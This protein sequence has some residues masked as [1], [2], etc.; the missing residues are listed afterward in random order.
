MVDME[1]PED[2]PYVRD[3]DTDFEDTGEL[4]RERARE[5]VELLREAI[6]YH[7]HRYYVENDPVISDRVYDKLFDRLEQ[8]EKEFDLASPNSPTRR[9]G[10]EPVEE[11]ETVEHV[12][13][14]LSL[15]SSEEEQDVRSF[16]E[17]VRKEVGEV[18]YHCEPKFDGISI[19]IVYENGEYQGAV[20]RGNGVEGE[21]VSEN[22]RTIRSVPLELTHAPDFLAVRGEVFMP[23]TGF[24]QLNEERIKA[25]KDPFANPRN[26]A[27][28]TVRQLDPSKVAARPLDIY[29]Y[30]ILQDSEEVEDHQRAMEILEKLGFQVNEHNTLVS[31]IDGFIDYRER[32]VEMRD[33]L[34]YE[35]DGV[36]VKVNDY[37]ARR[38]LGTTASHPRWAFAY[39]FPAKKEETTVRKIAVQVG[40]TGKLTPVALLEPVD[41]HGVTVSR[42]TL[43]NASQVEKMGVSEGA[44]VRIERAGD[45]IP[46]VVEVVEE[47]EGGFEMPPECP[48]CNSEVEVEG[49]YHFCT[50][51]ISCEAQLKRS[52][53]HFTSRGA[54][55]IEGVGERISSQLVES[56]LVEE[57]P[58]IYS[59]E[60]NDILELDKFAERSAEKLLSEIEESKQVELSRFIFALGIRHVGKETARV[61]SR[62][63]TLEQLMEADTEDLQE[64]EEIGPEVAESI[65]S[66]FS[67][68][69]GEVV[70]RF[71]KAG[72]EPGREE[73]GDELEGLKLVLTGSIED[74]NRDELV[75][76]LERNGADVTSS[77]SGETDYL[78]VGDNPGET[79]LDDAEEQDVE[80]IDKEEFRRRILRRIT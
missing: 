30:D 3:V 16:D 1:E 25:G 26:A 51:G 70:D 8:L 66:F 52:L 43:H 56:G 54:M 63:F 77:V 49:K 61:L 60:K 42:A 62:N 69:G 15:D 11:L 12:E 9:V 24:H 65:R 17:R 40:R 76:L 37:S 59:L 10:A 71:L 45:V 7:D 14:M 31:D 6:N 27:A 20:T 33:E 5:Q 53:E 55:D 36:V 32:M 23:R 57:V 74:Y 67:G 2:N 72:V 39:K 47:G 19:E 50:G 58:D 4:N 44:R 80:Q 64:I 29:F 75:E 38:E 41:V 79:K 22:V 18:E 13:E 21:D 35:I 48:V 28:G 73:R 46:E 78:V 34:D 68:Q